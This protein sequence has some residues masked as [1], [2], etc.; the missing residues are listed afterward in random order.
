M[1]GR[2]ETCSWC[3]LQLLVPPEA[4]TVQCAACQA[5]TPVRPN[6][7]WVQVHDSIYNAANRFKSLVNSAVGAASGN[8]Y[9]ASNAPVYGHY[10]QPPGPAPPLTLPS[11]HG[12]KRALLCGVSYNGHGN[13]LK[14]SVNDVRCM[15]YFLVE[16][17][18]FPGD[19]ILILTGINGS[20]ELEWQFKILARGLNF[21][22]II[23]T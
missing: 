20:N 4:Q 23:P 21:L 10:P 6:D 3:G 15:R 13:K 1:A 19:S 8:R 2:R 12:R 16:K 14:G 17:L 9:P 7:A 22:I 5:I 18:G 11:S